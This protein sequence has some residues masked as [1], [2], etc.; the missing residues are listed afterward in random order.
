MSLWAWLLISTC[1]LHSRFA[2]LNP[3]C[4]IKSRLDLK[5]G[6]G[7][8]LQLEVGS[9]VIVYICECYDVDIHLEK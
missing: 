5:I 6:V 4:A 7:N 1:F 8:L 9:N 3:I 2:F